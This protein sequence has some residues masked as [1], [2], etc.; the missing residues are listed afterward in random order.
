MTMFDARLDRILND[1][2]RLVAAITPRSGRAAAAGATPQEGRPTTAPTPATDHVIAVLEPLNVYRPGGAV[3]EAE[4]LQA[5]CREV[6]AKPTFNTL[7]V[8]QALKRA[9]APRG[10]EFRGADRLLV[11]LRDI[12]VIRYNRLRPSLGWDVVQ[13]GARQADEPARSFPKPPASESL[14]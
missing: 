2:A 12:G 5:V 9:G 13:T 14:R 1:H 8:R 10:S 7:Q 3:I 11:K 6:L 4:T